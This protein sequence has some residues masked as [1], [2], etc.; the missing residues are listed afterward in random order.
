[1]A[2]AITIG[3]TLKRRYTDTLK[4]MSP[5]YKRWDVG[6]SRITKGGLS[7]SDL[8]ASLRHATMSS[9]GEFSLRWILLKVRRDV[10]EELHNLA[11]KLVSG[12]NSF[13]SID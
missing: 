5:N 6:L 2:Q 8:H 7:N 11:G 4:F 10:S 1:M 9:N 12:S 3:V 13:G